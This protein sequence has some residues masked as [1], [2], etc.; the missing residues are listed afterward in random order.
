MPYRGCVCN[1]YSR[2]FLPPLGASSHRAKARGQA[3]EELPSVALRRL[4]RGGRVERAARAAGPGCRSAMP[5]GPVGPAG[6]RNI[7]KENG[8]RRR[9]RPPPRSGAGPLPCPGSGQGG[10][11]AAWTLGIGGEPS[12][13]SVA[14]PTPG[15]AVALPALSGGRQ[16]RPYIGRLVWS[17]AIA[18]S[19]SRSGSIGGTGA[20]SAGLWPSGRAVSGGAAL[21]PWAQSVTCP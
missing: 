4:A 10:R 20:A 9:P 15:R 2:P 8:G 6:I 7:A 19:P 17:P 5:V 16:A 18:C 21:R 3:E 13:S 1:V 14:A 11:R 12:H